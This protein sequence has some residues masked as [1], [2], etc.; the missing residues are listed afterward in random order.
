MAQVS[1]DTWHDPTKVEIFYL[2]QVTCGML[3]LAKDIYKYESLER[4]IL[5]INQESKEASL[6]G[7]VLPQKQGEKRLVGKVGPPP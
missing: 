1:R 6:S 5:T 3:G 4:V 2:I 7:K